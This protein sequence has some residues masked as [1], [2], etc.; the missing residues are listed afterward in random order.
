MFS[1][2]PIYIPLL[3]KY[4][5]CLQLQLLIEL[6]GAEQRR[7]FLSLVQQTGKT[8]TFFFNIIFT[9]ICSND[10]NLIDTFLLASHL[11]DLR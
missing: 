11:A 1:C 9:S 6:D 4:S 5:H 10:Y 8:Q 2:L 3:M 7:E